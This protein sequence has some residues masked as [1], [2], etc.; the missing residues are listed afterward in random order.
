MEELS[1]DEIKRYSRHLLLREFGKEGQLKLKR[2]SVLV[3]GAGGLGCPVLLYLTAAGVGT[4]GIADFDTVD[5]S[6]LQRQVIYTLDDVGQSKAHSAVLR[7]KQSNPHVTFREFNERLTSQNAINYIKDFDVVVDGTDNFATRYLLNDACIL[8]DKPL[9]YGSILR[10]EGHVSV[11]NFKMKNGERSTNYRDLFPLPPDPDSVPNCEEAGVLGVLPGMIGTIQANEVI[12]IINGVHEPLINT[13]L[14]LDAETMDI[15]KIKIQNH[16]TRSAIKELIDYDL[17]CKSEQKSKPLTKSNEANMK[18]ITVQD[19]KKMM[20]EGTDFQ[21]ID[22]REEHEFEICNLGGELI[23]L[24]DVPQNVDKVD[25]N[26][27]VVIHCRSG[28]R[29]GDSVLWLERNHKFENLYN[30]KGGI[31]AWA[32]EI[33][34]SMPSY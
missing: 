13:L 33:D 15:T 2:A 28:K 4:I 9:V 18:E 20:D 7:L 29:S 5:I 34:P 16:G 21:L 12:K 30:L 24:A 19:L 1:S 27:Q 25:K 31:L 32:R 23:P 22:V 6:N 17:F 3:V 8:L 10:F 14:I 26:K 11:F